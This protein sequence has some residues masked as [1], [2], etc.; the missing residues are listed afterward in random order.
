R[1]PQALSRRRIGFRDALTG[2]G[3]EAAR[4]HVFKMGASVDLVNYDILKDNDGTPRFL[5][6]A[7]YDYQHPFELN[8]GTGDASLDENNTQIRLY[9]QDD[10]SPSHRLTINAGIRW[11][12]ESHMSNA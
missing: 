6:N 2:T 8:Y 11:A 1:R 5:Y 4:Q 12:L 9:L 3:L 7:A 10:C